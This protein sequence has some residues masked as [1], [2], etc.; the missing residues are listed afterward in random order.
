[1]RKTKIVKSDVKII[2][3]NPKIELEI[4]SQFS[5]EQLL[6]I[7]EEISKIKKEVFLHEQVCIGGELLGNMLR[8]HDYSKVVLLSEYVDRIV[9]KLQVRPAT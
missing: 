6:L 2:K 5:R 9:S 7:R 8:E 1:M 3:T 4:D